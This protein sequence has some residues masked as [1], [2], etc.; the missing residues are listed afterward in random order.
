[1]GELPV[2]GRELAIRG[3]RLRLLLSH[4]ADCDPQGSHLCGKNMSKEL[5]ILR[6][7]VTEGKNR[8]NLGSILL[9][10]VPKYQVLLWLCA[11]S[12]LLC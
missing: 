12:F 4:R 9:V 2:N 10:L 6:H 1:M 7:C 11:D 5:S 3:W 8:E